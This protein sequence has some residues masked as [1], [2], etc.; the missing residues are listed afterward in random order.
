MQI[1]IPQEHVIPL[2]ENINKTA[3]KYSYGQ[4]KHKIIIQ[5]LLGNEII[6]FRLPLNISYP[7]YDKNDIN[8]II[9]LIQSGSCSLGMYE[10]GINVDHKVFKSYM[11]RKKQGKSQIKYLKTKGKSRA[12]SRVRLGNTVEFFEN[13]NHR[14]QE[15]FDNWTVNR[16]AMSCS[17]ILIPYLFNSKVQCPFSKK[18]D[19]IYKIPKHIETPNHEVLN[20]VNRFLLKGHLMY[21]EENQ[22]L[23]DEILD[24]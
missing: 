7:E 10:D 17:K 23:V 8:Y 20:N 13:I 14:L 16:I 6:N 21:N 1:S 12:G 4:E 9:L 5:D 24:I 2:I 18:D 19:R 11:V 15:Y 22:D 3:K